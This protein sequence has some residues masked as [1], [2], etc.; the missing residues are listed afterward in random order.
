[1]SDSQVTPDL[2][3]WIAEQSALGHKPEALLG[4]MLGSGWAARAAEQ[5]LDEVLRGRPLEADQVT[6]LP[7]PAPVPDLSADSVG[8]QVIASMLNPRIVILGAMLS[9]DEC[10]ELVA[11]AQPRLARSETLELATGGNAVHEARTSRGM[12]FAREENPLCARIERR[13]AEWFGWPLE[14]GEGLQVLHYG[15]GAEYKPHYDY[16]DP[17]Q[18]GTAPVL[19]RGGQRVASVVMYLNTPRRGGG[20]VFPDVQFEVAPIKGN[21][22]F[23]SYDRP[24]PATHSLHGGS[25]VI[26]GEKWVA[27]K[28]LRERRFE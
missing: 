26:E 17:A 4:S 2:R 1:M 5:A 16:F 15:P 19:K 13:I 23:F 27:T 11:L 24:H 28:W 14:N 12:F 10:D 6:G 3:R 22:V 18:P 7:V 20:T 21:A 9:H 8:A 25:P